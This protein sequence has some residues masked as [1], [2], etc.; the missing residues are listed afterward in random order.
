V[1]R[2]LRQLAHATFLGGT[3]P[4]AIELAERLV[5]LAP[6]GLT[7][8]FYS[9]DG[10]T[11]MEVALKMAFQYWQQNGKP[12][13]TAFVAFEE[14]YHGD[15]IGAVS[16]GAIPIFHDRFKPLL[17]P[18]LKLPLDADALEKTL[19]A[20][21]E[22][23]AGVCVEPLVQGAGG[24]ILNS[25]AFVRRVRE[26]CAKHDTFMIA[27]EVLTGF[28]RTG[29]MF[30]C[31]QARITPDL[32]AL[33]KGL[34]GGYLPLGATLATE[35]IYEGF[36]G[37]YASTRTFFHGHT[38]T[39]NPLGC[40]AALG[41]LRFLKKDRTLEKLGPKIAAFQSRL[42]ALK[43]VDVRVCGLMAGVELRGFPF[44][45]REG[46]RRIL[47]AREK[48]VLLRPLGNT[49]V[50]MPPLTISERE[51]GFLLGAVEEI[52]GVNRQERQERQDGRDPRFG[53]DA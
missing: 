52:V 31:E 39:G 20:R 49:I 45:A 29:T 14:G 19:A 44:E 24:M 34:T 1:R 5:A 26:L 28:G 6:K 13:R 27:D 11:A 3:N 36:L 35:R 8:V 47:M 33:S 21:A 25:P 7:R 15:T 12:K 38:Y 48:G 17:F 23:I 18:T 53:A 2:Q 22:E 9:D 16:A 4:V 30:A 51:M 32:M 43:D 42:K 40:A 37:D 41:T 46:H 10:S 50:V